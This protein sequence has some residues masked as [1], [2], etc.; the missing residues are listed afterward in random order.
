[1]ILA[2]DGGG[3]DTALLELLLLRL[4]LMITVRMLENGVNNWGKNGVPVC[5][6]VWLSVRICAAT[7]S[8]RMTMLPPSQKLVCSRSSSHPL[9]R[10]LKKCYL[11]V[12]WEAPCLLL[13]VFSFPSFRTYQKRLLFCSGR[14]GTWTGGVFALI[15]LSATTGA[16]CC[17]CISCL[18]SLLASV[19][20]SWFWFTV[21]LS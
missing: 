15:C 20:W 17:Y 11:V 19:P 18:F 3:D 2:R 13:V 5:T 8:S 12:E 9:Q 16:M 10:W 6:L 21:E 4:P 7:L 1:M 14:R